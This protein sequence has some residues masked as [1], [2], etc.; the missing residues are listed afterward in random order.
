MDG[1]NSVRH[2]Q[3]KTCISK[4]FFDREGILL[5]KEN[6]QNNPPL[7]AMAKLMLNSFWGRFGMRPDLMRTQI[8][9][10]GED[11]RRLILNDT[12]I[13]HSILPINQD[14]M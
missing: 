11:L 4:K 8:V 10:T 7:R 5:E 6:I 9:K 1:L 3:I 14:T 13:V 12:F 2:S